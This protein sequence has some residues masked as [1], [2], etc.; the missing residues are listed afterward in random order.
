M[1]S[2]FDRSRLLARASGAAGI[3]TLACCGAALPA[4]A[5]TVEVTV[6]GVEPGAGRVLASLCSGGLDRTACPVGQ[7]QA[8]Q[9]PVVSFRFDDV[10]PGRYAALAFQDIEGDGVLRRSRM[11]RPLEP[12]GLSN[13]AGRAHSPSFEQ[14]AVRVGEGGARIAVRLDRPAR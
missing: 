8:P 13:G 3:A 5:A 2:R 1:P 9:G 6:T 7:S 11:G 4:G 14:A 12:Y 10:E